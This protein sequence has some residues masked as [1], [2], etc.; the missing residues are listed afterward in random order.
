MNGSAAFQY[1]WH[2][3]VEI[4]LGLKGETAV[5]IRNGGVTLGPGKILIIGS[6]ESHSILPGDMEAER[7]AIH[8]STAFLHDERLSDPEMSGVFSR[9]E[10]F[11]DSWG[12]EDVKSIWGYVGNIWREYVEKQS[13]WR[14]I[15]LAALLDRNAARSSGVPVGALSG[16]YQPGQLR[17]HPAL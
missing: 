4:L 6:G 11:S 16:G 7:L 9:I 10:G 3:A 5:G 1:H 13:G 12:A 15:C 17:G 8:F 2:E 14:E